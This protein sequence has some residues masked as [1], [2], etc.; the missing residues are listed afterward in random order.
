MGK[1]LMIIDG[2]IE[3]IHIKTIEKNKKEFLIK[4]NDTIKNL[5]KNNNILELIDKDVY[6]I[7]ITGK[8]AGIIKNTIKK[9]RTIIQSASLWSKAK[10][11][12]INNESVDSI[13]IIDLSASGYM[14]IC[15]NNK[16]ELKDDLLEINPKCGAGSGIN[17][18]RILEKLNIQKNEVDRILN[19]YLGEK[20][21]KAREE[22]HI[23]SDRC[24]VFSSSATISDKNQGIPL[25]MA[26][27]VTMKSEVL[28]PCKKML[29]NTSKVILTGRVFQWQYTRDCAKDYLK[30]NR[31]KRDNI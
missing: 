19:K 26:L 4:N 13:G 1:K 21:K 11:I 31:R 15:V 23:R 12:A 27:A 29:P 24:G 9:G 5:F 22:V 28:K 3:H 6:E 17:L 2:G 30:K 7:F 20:G 8:L 16:G 25:D 18:G 14:V 10:S